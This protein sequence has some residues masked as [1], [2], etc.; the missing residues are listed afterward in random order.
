MIILQMTDFKVLFAS[1]LFAKSE[2]FFRKVAAAC[3]TSKRHVDQ[4][5]DAA[6]SYFEFF[7]RNLRS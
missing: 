2:L 4:E 1:L 7:R 5:N 3:M 6:A